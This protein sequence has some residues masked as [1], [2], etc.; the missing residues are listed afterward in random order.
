MASISL[1]TFNLQ[2]RNANWKTCTQA[3]SKSLKRVKYGVLIIFGFHSFYLEEVE[4]TDIKCQH[5]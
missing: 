4:W 2:I 5:T 1:L 3:Q